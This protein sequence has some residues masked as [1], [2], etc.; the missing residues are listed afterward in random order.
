[1]M[2]R[3]RGV[4]QAESELPMFVAANFHIYGRRHFQMGSGRDLVSSVMHTRLPSKRLQFFF[5]CSTEHFYDTKEGNTSFF[6]Y[7]L[8]IQS[9]FGFIDSF[10]SI[11]IQ[12]KKKLHNH[13]AFNVVVVLP[14]FVFF[15]DFFF[16]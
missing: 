15:S 8:A 9:K 5:L 6:Y 14:Y 13:I 10:K 4:E 7:T 11:R 12:I 3:L 16:F 2:I 1:M